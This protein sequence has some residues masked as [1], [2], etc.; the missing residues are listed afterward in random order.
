MSSKCV[1]TG[2]VSNVVVT[3]RGKWEDVYVIVKDDSGL[4]DVFVVCKAKFRDAQDAVRALS[5][6]DEVEIIGRVTSREWQPKDGGDPKWFTDMEV[7]SVTVVKKE[8][9]KPKDPPPGDPL[10]KDGIPF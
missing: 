3:S 1:V 9:A 4:K 2:K 6:G 8:V 7:N 5:K 10:D